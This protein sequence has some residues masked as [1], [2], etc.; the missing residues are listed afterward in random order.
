MKILTEASGS[1]VSAYLIKAIKESGNIA[2]ASDVNEDNH[3]QCLADEFITFP[4]SNIPDLWEV[5]E[6]KLIQSKI[7]IVIPS[8]DETLLGWAERK[9][10][11]K[12]KGIHV[13]I[14][15][16]Q[17]LNTFLDKYSAYEFCQTH[18][19]PTPKTS[20]SQVYTLV[21]PRFGRGGSGIYIGDEPQNMDEMI[22]Q[23]LIDGLEYTVDCLFDKDGNPIYI[24]PRIRMDVKDGKSTKG[25]V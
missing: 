23:E 20:L 8:F 17:S 7:D 13:L 11:F 16:S 25:I 3:G 24:I 6:T 12:Q 15:D 9:E 19:I 18:N 2:V 1:L 22:S 5:I 21:K 4:Y 14:S 10:Y